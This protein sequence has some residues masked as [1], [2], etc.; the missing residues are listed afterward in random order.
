MRLGGEL[1]SKPTKA[2]LIARVAQLEALVSGDLAKAYLL[3][4]GPNYAKGGFEFTIQTPMG[5]I[6]AEF[7]CET[8][9][10]SGAP[11]YVALSANHREMGELEFVVRRVRGT[12]IAQKLRLQHDALQSAESFIVDGGQ[13][14]FEPAS[15]VL[16]QIRE[17]MRIPEPAAL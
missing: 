14:D 10:G 5:Q 13:A 2:E 15:Q 17:A 9:K 7:M 16:T 3:S 8:L 12:A 1:M 11:N 6:L 4:A